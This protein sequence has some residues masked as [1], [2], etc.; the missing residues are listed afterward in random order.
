MS[1]QGTWL[2]VSSQKHVSIV[3]RVFEDK[4]RALKSPLKERKLPITLQ[5]KRHRNKMLQAQNVQMAVR[6]RGIYTEGGGRG[7]SVEQLVKWLDPEYKLREKII[8]LQYLPLSLPQRVR[9]SYPASPSKSFIILT[10]YS[11]T[12]VPLICIST[13]GTGP[14]V[15]ADYFTHSKKSSMGII[16]IFI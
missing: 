15:E 10:L 5:R 7:G 1:V 8:C 14:K 9:A 4:C 3:F 12:L 11:R 6:Q 2:C 13:R 16:K